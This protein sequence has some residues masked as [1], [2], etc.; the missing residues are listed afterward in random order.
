MELSIAC[1]NYN[2]L[3]LLVVEQ[4]ALDNFTYLTTDTAQ[5]ESDFPMQGS[6][7]KWNIGNEYLGLTYRQASLQAKADSI[8]YEVEND[9]SDE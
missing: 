1:R 3:K 9:E 4:S 8:E 7:G 6:D 5:I 2:R